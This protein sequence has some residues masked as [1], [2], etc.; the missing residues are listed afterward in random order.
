MAATLRCPRQLAEERG[1]LVPVRD[2]RKVLKQR[3]T[4]F[5]LDSQG[6][7]LSVLK[8]SHTHTHTHT[9]T[10]SGRQG[11]LVLDE[12]SFPFKQTKLGV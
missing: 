1:L 3:G 10:P 9:H 5:R 4:L 6:Q 12:I 2:G 7:V 11:F 8:A